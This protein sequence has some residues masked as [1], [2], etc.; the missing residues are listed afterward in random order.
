MGARVGKRAGARPPSPEELKEAFAA[1]GLSPRRWENSAGYAYER[2]SHGYHK[3]LYCATGSITFHTDDG[4]LEL[5]AG[6][7]LDIEPGTEH[8][9]TVGPQ[10]VQCWEAAR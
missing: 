2:H 3:V 1:E 6:D 7:R 4:D 9:A 10:G 8:S 5:N